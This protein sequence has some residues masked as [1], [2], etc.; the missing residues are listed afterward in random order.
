V[1]PTT[2]A[3]PQSRPQHIGFGPNYEEPAQPGVNA[4]SLAGRPA[5]KTASQQHPGA[6]VPPGSY[7]PN[8]G[9]KHR[10]DAYDGD[11]R[12]AA[13][14][15]MVARNANAWRTPQPSGRSMNDGRSG[16]MTYTAPDDIQQM[17]MSATQAYCSAYNRYLE[18]NPAADPDDCDAAGRAAARA[19]AGDSAACEAI[20]DAAWRR[21]C[22]RNQNAWRKK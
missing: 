21:M 9:L 8:L 7:R 6:D 11:P 15:A 17:G 22:E 18:N 3:P 14:A 5:H 13:Y 20:R 12:A 19:F 4:A 10:K 16:M 1:P 2:G